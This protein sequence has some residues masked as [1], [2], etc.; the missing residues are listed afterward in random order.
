MQAL[1]KLLRTWLAARMGAYPG[2]GAL[3]LPETSTGALGC[4]ILLAGFRS[5]LSGLGCRR[6]WQWL[7]ASFLVHRL[8]NFSILLSG[9]RVQHYFPVR[10]L[11]GVSVLH[12]HILCILSCLHWWWLQYSRRNLADIADCYVHS[13]HVK[14]V[15]ALHCHSFCYGAT[16]TAAK[17]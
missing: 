6:W 12:W 4:H 1:Q 9:I 10:S 17:T 3:H 14:M 7:K 11:E 13:L 15:G 5:S 8:I 16:K 2:V